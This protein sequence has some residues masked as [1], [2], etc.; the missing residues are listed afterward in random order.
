MACANNRET[1]LV[2]T[3]TPFPSSS[4]RS[5]NLLTTTPSYLQA[6]L[7]SH[8]QR[9]P[10]TWTIPYSPNSLPIFKDISSFQGNAVILDS[11]PFKTTFV[12]GRIGHCDFL[13]GGEI[14]VHRSKGIL[15]SCSFRVLKS[16]LEKLGVSLLASVLKTSFQEELVLYYRGRCYFFFSCRFYKFSRS[17][18]GS[19]GGSTQHELTVSSSS[20]GKLL[21]P[22]RVASY[23]IS[24][25]YALKRRWR[26]RPSQ[27][28]HQ[29][30]VRFDSGFLDKLRLTYHILLFASPDSRVT[31]LFPP[32]K[33][34]CH[35]PIQGTVIFCYDKWHKHAPPA[36]TRVEQKYQSYYFLLETLDRA[37]ST[38]FREGKAKM[39]EDP[40]CETARSSRNRSH[41]T[42]VRR[43]LTFLELR[44]QG[45]RACQEKQ[46]LQVYNDYG[47]QIYRTDLGQVDRKS[48]ELAKEPIV[49]LFTALRI[50]LT[51]VEVNT[52]CTLSSD[53]ADSGSPL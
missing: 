4:T 51:F 47:V 3:L 43:L 41:V 34:L 39:I 21:K 30:V 8:G 52:P 49:I 7:T 20:W 18:P 31:V 26:D 53:I 33:A 13:K 29:E 1:L 19:P 35:L 17:T 14:Q 16:V 37:T 25:K 27:R 6:S 42:G 32:L 24:P 44:S 48:G 36:L 38:R 11:A 22:I 15:Q 45:S 46:V 10:L 23:M 2:I 28:F 5:S 12:L 50:V 9:N 40:A